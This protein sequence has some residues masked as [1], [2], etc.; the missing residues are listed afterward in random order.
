MSSQSLCYMRSTHTQS[1]P[2][3]WLQLSFGGCFQLFVSYTH[4]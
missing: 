2:L 3:R 1:Q 4:F